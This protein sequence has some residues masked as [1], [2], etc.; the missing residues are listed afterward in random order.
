MWKTRNRTE[1][2]REELSHEMWYDLTYSQIQTLILIFNETEKKREYTTIPWKFNKHAI[3]LIKFWLV[4]WEKSPYANI[5]INPENG[6]DYWKFRI[7]TE[8]VGLVNSIKR[9]IK[10]EKNLTSRENL[11]IWANK[12]API[13]PFLA[14]IIAFF[15]LI[16]SIIAL[17]LSN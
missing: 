7:K 13:L 6:Y 1:D 16:I 12:Q 4:E 5:F 15:S 11:V 3:D 8:W 9:K 17:C 10:K 2:E 14:L